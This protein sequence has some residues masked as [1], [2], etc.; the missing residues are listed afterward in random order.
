MDA[1]WRSRRR[2]RAAHAGGSADPRHPDPLA[3]GRHAR[4]ARAGGPVTS[5]L[6]HRTPRLRTVVL[7]QIRLVRGA[8]RVPAL[9]A[10]ALLA[11]ATLLL[12]IELKDARTSIAFHPE[13]HIL[14][15]VLAVLLA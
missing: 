1:A 3:R 14:P 2:D 13:H 7:A 11:V 15:A 9:G 5:A 6:P 12:A 10:A 4:A 8:L